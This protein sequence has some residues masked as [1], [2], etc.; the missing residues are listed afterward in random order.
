[1]RILDNG[2]PAPTGSSH[3]EA[4]GIAIRGTQSCLHLT[5]SEISGNRGD[6]A[7]AIFLTDQPT[8]SIKTSLIAGNQARFAGAIYIHD[9]QTTYLENVTISGNLGN[10]GAILNDGFNN[11]T[12]VHCTV[13]QNSA[14]GTGTNVGGI[15]DVHGGSGRTFL[16]NT[17]LSGN[18]PGFQADDCVAATS[19]GGGNLIGD[20]NQ[21]SAMPNDQV[22]VLVNLGLLGEHGGFTRTH[23]V[24]DPAIDAAADGACVAIDQR[25]L[26]RPVDG[27]GDG[28]AH[29]DSGAVEHQI[30][31]L[32][33]DGFDPPQAIA[34][35]DSSRVQ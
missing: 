6:Q 1:V 27:D 5:D 33:A 12:L 14:S 34:I 2:D 16:S 21:L 10:P 32:F 23:S 3:P 8:V 17:L 9:A 30:D 28:I 31:P 25:G 7:G 11:L 26:P 22:G 19:V 18:G 29:C 15:Q 24:P 4:G 13:T 35:R 20:C